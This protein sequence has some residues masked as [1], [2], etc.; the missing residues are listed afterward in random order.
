M[1]TYIKPE[2]NVVKLELEQMVATSNVS[3]EIYQ[4]ESGTAETKGR[5]GTWGNLWGNND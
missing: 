1:N 2:V 4:E 5:R 3:F